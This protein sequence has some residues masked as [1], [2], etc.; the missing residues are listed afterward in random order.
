MRLAVGGDD[1]QPACR[2]DLRRFTEQSTLAY[3]RRPDN[4]DDTSGA[5][6]G[7]VEDCRDRVEFPAASDQTRLGATCRLVFAGRQQPS[8]PRRSVATLYLYEFEVT[9]DSGVLYKAGR[10]FAEHHTAGRRD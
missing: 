4:S 9:E 8:G 5:V 10:R 2:C 7:F 3:A 6:D 1:L